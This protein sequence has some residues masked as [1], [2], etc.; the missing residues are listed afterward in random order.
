MGYQDIITHINSFFVCILLEQEMSR[1]VSSRRENVVI[2]Y[3][4]Q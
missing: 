2:N 4:K 1:D 3:S